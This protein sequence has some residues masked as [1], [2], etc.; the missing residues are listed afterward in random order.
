LHVENRRTLNDG[1]RCATV[2]DV[3]GREMWRSRVWDQVYPPN[4]GAKLAEL[5]VLEDGSAFW[6]PAEGDVLVPLEDVPEHWKAQSAALARIRSLPEIKALCR[7]ATACDLTVSGYPSANCVTESEGVACA[8]SVD[9]SIVHERMQ[10]YATFYVRN[11]GEISVS[12]A[13]S[14]EGPISLE[15]W[16]C[17]ASGSQRARCK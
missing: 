5:V 2:F 7:K 8:W 11:D 3:I 4:K 12:E 10:R 16:R 15:V 13:L 9:V 17:R 6:R 14:E 1:G